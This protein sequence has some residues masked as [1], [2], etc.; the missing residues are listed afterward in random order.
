MTSRQDARLSNGAKLG[1][2]IPNERFTRVEQCWLTRPSNVS[3]L[4]RTLWWDVIHTDVDNI[5]SAAQVPPSDAQ[6]IHNQGSRRGVDE[7]CRVRLQSAFGTQAFSWGQSAHFS[8][9]SPGQL[10]RNSPGLPDQTTIGIETN[11]GQLSANSFPPAEILDMSLDLYFRHFQPLIPF[12]H[13]PTYCAKATPL[14]LLFTQC[15]IG[16][17]ILGTTGATTFVS[18]AYPLTLAKMSADMTTAALGSGTPG[19]ILS[20]FAAAFL[21][22]NLALLTGERENLEQCQML[23]VNL[24]SV[25]QRHGLFTDNEG[26]PLDTS[27]L[28]SISDLDQRWKAWSRIESTKRSFFLLLFYS[29]LADFFTG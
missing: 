8:T 11:L 14:P 7:E 28:E 26:H 29:T 5:F 25:A 12:I 2:N 3:R 4:I 16:L 17:V 27:Q 19:S 20:T 13:A 22:L 9:S 23:Y 18:K 6:Y 15:L 21:M 1:D 24:I 10:S